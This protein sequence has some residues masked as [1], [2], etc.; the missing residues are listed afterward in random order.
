MAEV[1]ITDSRIRPSIALLIVCS[2]VGI[3]GLWTFYPPPEDNKTALAM[4]NTLIGLLGGSSAA[5]VSYYFGSSS[6]STQKDTTLASIATSTG[7]GPGYLSNGNGQPA[8]VVN[9]ATDVSVT[10]EDPPADATKPTEVKT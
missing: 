3:M 8:I 9:K 10:S 5:V 6:S 4:L 1:Q 7:T 2:F